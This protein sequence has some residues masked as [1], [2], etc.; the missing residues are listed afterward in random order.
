MILSLANAATDLTGPVVSARDAFKNAVGRVGGSAD[1]DRIEA[2]PRRDPPDLAT[3]TSMAE[4]MTLRLA[5]HGRIR[6]DGTPCGCSIHTLLPIQG[7]YLTEASRCGGALGMLAVGAGKT[8]IGL[9]LPMVFPGVR[10]AVLLVPPDLRAQLRADYEEWS[11]HFETPNAAGGWST[12][13]RG[14]LH[15]PGRPSLHV[16]AYSEL[17]HEGCATWLSTVR[18]D[19]V[20]A[21][22]AQSLANRDSVRTSRFLGYLSGPKCPATTKYCG[23]SGSMT[24]NSLGQYSHHAALALGEGSPVP[25]DQGT[26]REWCGALDPAI[27]GMGADAGELKRL[28]SPDEKPRAGFARRLLETAGVI[29]TAGAIP[30]VALHL[31]TR[32]P[33][34]TPPEVAA[35]LS[36]TRDSATRPDGSPF[37]EQT[38][39]VA[40]LRQIAAGF[41]YRW[42]Y[43]RGEQVSLIEEWFAARKAWFAELREMLTSRSELLDSPLLL[44]RAAERSM[45]PHYLG[46]APT[47][48]SSAWVPWRD[49]RA[50]VQPETATVWLSDWLAQDAVAWG[51]ERP[52][53]IWY[54]HRAMG[55]RIAKLGGL[56]W[57]GQGEE[58][59]ERILGERGDRTIV[60]SRKAHGKG[61]NL[62]MF[63]RMLFTGVPSDEGAWEQALGRCHRT[64]QVDTVRA[65]TYQHTGELVQALDDAREKA[66]YVEQ[67]TRTPRKLLY[68]LP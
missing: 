47:W 13:P 21:D 23:H 4:D 49:I 44:R 11:Q 56:P 58:A 61:K 39:V 27:R 63:A 38:E 36:T 20:I 30:P 60:A 3:Q 34:A 64:R 24:T 14:R 42:V 15:I 54:E 2:L 25:I 12:G 16:L 31:T 57:Y 22:E 43:P 1:L 67:T 45:D 5:A 26:V 59:S 6:A 62:Q 46:D 32:R 17:S 29:T 50:K 35:A 37:T 28:C 48:D 18:P 7:W 10:V 68:A 9:L 19:L 53:I 55:E 8:G 40:C 41:Y 52:G 33:P 51:A 66:R 65:W